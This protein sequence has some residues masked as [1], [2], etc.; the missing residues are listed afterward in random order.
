MYQEDRLKKQTHR[1]KQFGRIEELSEGIKALLKNESSSLFSWL[2]KGKKEELGSKKSSDEKSR[3]L[4]DPAEKEKGVS[5]LIKDDV[6]KDLI[7]VDIPDDFNKPIK[8]QVQEYSYSLDTTY[9]HGKEGNS[10]KRALNVVVDFAPCRLVTIK[11]EKEELGIENC[12][13]AIGNL[14]FGWCSSESSDEKSRKLLD[15]AEKEKGVSPLI[16]DDVVKDL[17]QV[18]NHA[19]F[20]EPIEDQ[21]QEYSYFLDT[22]YQHGNEGNSLRRALNVGVDFAPC[23][24]VTSTGLQ[25][26]SSHLKGLVFFLGA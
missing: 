13:I 3:K 2:E 12:D 25:P 5:P 15:P 7:Q 20:N 17:I 9:Q 18:N 6:V 1:E 10:L 22:T 14:E 26:I 19:D 11:G 16:K 4:L 8:D 23:R 24:L 21:V